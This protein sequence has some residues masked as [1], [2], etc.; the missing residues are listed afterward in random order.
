MGI[1]ISLFHS[2]DNHRICRFFR[3][4]HLYECDEQEEIGHKAGIQAGNIHDD[5][6]FYLGGGSHHH[7]R[8]KTQQPL[9][10]LAGLYLHCL[11]HLL[12]KVDDQGNHHPL[13]ESSRNIH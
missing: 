5:N 1:Q 13:H 9:L 6:A 2:A 11:P 12:K 10:R 7:N 4:L 3:D 8:V